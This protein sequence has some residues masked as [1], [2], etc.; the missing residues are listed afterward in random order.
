VATTRTLHHIR[1]PSPCKVV[2]QYDLEEDIYDPVYAPVPEDE[3]EERKESGELDL[4]SDKE[5]SSDEETDPSQSAES[6]TNQEIR[7]A[8]IPVEIQT[9][10]HSRLVT[11]SILSPPVLVTMPTT[12]TAPVQTTT[13]TSGSSHP[14]P[15]PATPQDI[16]DSI[17]N[18]LRRGPHPGQP[19]GGAGGGGAGGP[20]G[21]GPAQPAQA[22]QQPIAI[23]GN[24]KTMEQLPQTFTGDRTKTDAF[25]DE[26]KGYLNSDVAGFISPIKK[27]AFTLTLIKGPETHQGLRKILATQRGARD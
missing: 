23:A 5:D 14:T 4:P 6:T 20:P 8:S 2:Q 25:I 18:A 26:V 13:G 19:G 12:Q 17:R 10:R 16:R 1:Q 24:V 15:A 27:V 9:P 11:Q 3:E 22:P 21:P 7:K